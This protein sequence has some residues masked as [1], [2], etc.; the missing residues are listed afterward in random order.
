MGCW[1]R[2][3]QF[4]FDLLSGKCIRWQLLRREIEVGHDKI[5]VAGKAGISLCRKIPCNSCSVAFCELLTIDHSSLKGQAAKKSR[6]LDP[7]IIPKAA[8][9]HSDC[10]YDPSKTENYLMWRQHREN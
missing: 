1:H 6:R 5:E 4:R 8:I 10:Q 2:F 7:H 3:I 9:H